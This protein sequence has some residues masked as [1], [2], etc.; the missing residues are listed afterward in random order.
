MT[1]AS[2]MTH[3]VTALPYSIQLMFEPCLVVFTALKRIKVNKSNFY[4][5]QNS[6]LE[7]ATEF[8]LQKHLSRGM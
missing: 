2:A 4:S 5:H 1:L 6:R 7:S 8:A 3:L